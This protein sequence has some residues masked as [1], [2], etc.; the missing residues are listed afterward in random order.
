MSL[1]Y[2]S[3]LCWA[4]P[5]FFAGE[6]LSLTFR[7]GAISSQTL[8]ICNLFV[9]IHGS[10]STHSIPIITLNLHPLLPFSLAPQISSSLETFSIFNLFVIGLLQLSLLVDTGDFCW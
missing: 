1:V 8:S 5:A 2:S 3:V 10:F 7:E 4:I 9:L 6:S